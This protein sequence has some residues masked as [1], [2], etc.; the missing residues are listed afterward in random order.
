MPASDWSEEELVALAL[1]NNIPFEN[2]SGANDIK[3]LNKDEILRVMYQHCEFEEFHDPVI[4]VKNQKSAVLPEDTPM[5][6]Y[7]YKAQ[8]IYTGNTPG[9]FL[10]IAGQNNFFVR[11][12]PINLGLDKL[13]IARALSKRSDFKVVFDH[14]EQEDSLS[15]TIRQFKE[16]M[17]SP[18]WDFEDDIDLD[19]FR[20]F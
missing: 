1:H 3:K 15:R 11:G 12:M 19:D 18:D 13:A 9:M 2:C 17:E 10:R 14:V 16:D 6:G 8:V 4:E 7:S 20:G 5:S